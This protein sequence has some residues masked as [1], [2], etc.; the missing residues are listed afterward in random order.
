MDENAC[1]SLTI[2]NPLVL[3][4]IKGKLVIKPAPLDMLHACADMH[5]KW[6]KREGVTMTDQYDDSSD[7]NKNRITFYYDD[8]PLIDSPPFQ[9]V[10]DTNGKPIGAWITS[11][12]SIATSRAFTMFAQSAKKTSAILMKDASTPVSTLATC[13]PR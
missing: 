7:N 9:D 4:I 8:P 1:L 10:P 13:C 5:G 11:Q 2:V 3:H 6:R 12:G